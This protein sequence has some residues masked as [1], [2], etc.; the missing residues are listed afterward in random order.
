V[1]V[2]VCA[3][4]CVCAFVWRNRK[5]ICVSIRS[6]QAKREDEKLLVII[7][8]SPGGYCLHFGV[9]QTGPKRHRLIATTAP[10]LQGFPSLLPTFVK[11]VRVAEKRTIFVAN[12]RRV[13]LSHVSS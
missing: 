7:A 12:V 6:F 1:E 5:P 3:C 8:L 10:T 9:D 11:R 4:M 2:V 13:N